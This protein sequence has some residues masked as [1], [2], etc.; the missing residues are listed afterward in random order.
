MS[1]SPLT[2]LNVQMLH[3]MLAAFPAEM[4]VNGVTESFCLA[5]YILKYYFGEDWLSRYVKPDTAVPNFLRA[6]ESDT[7]SQDRTALRVIDLAETIY[8]LQPILGFDECVEKMREGDIE[9]TYAELDLGRMLYLYKVPFRYVVRRGVKG[10][11]Y[12][13]EIEYPNGVIACAEAKCSIES[14][15]C[16]ESTIRNKLDSAR[17]QLPSDRPGIVF[18]KMPPTWMDESD[19]LKMTSDVAQS[20]LMGTK[21]IVSVKFYVS[22]ISIEG[23]CTK[24]RHAYKEISNPDT[25]FG[26]TK[27]WDLFHEMDLPPEYNGMPPHWQRVLFFPDGKER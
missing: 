22:P 15:M 9:G 10:Q 13:V 1:T 14:T 3:D 24:Q 26:A 27:N 21:R 6:D 11:D 18:V 17:K 23:A 2:R 16:G 20:F 25:R 4:R 19:F 8:N 7:T 12:D 5:A